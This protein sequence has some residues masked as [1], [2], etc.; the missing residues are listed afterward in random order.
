MKFPSPE[1][2]HFFR[3]ASICPE[4]KVADI[5]FNRDEIIKIIKDL[6]TKNVRLLLFPEL[7]I[8]GYTCGDLFYQNILQK[9]S[10]EAV[11]EIAAFVQ[12]EIVI[13]GLPLPVNGKLYNTAA[14]LSRGK[15]RAFIPKTY[16]PNTGEFYEER[17]FSSA[18]DSIADTIII[19][20]E[21]IPFGTDVLFT[22]NNFEGLKFGIEICEDL[23]AIEPPGIEMAKEGANLILNLSASNEILGKYHYRK[24]LVKQQSARCLSAYLYSSAGPG[25]SST[26]LVFSGH[27]LAAENGMVLAESR[28]Y[29]FETDTIIVDIDCEKLNQ[30]RVKNNSFGLSKPVKKF[31]E[32]H[33]SLDDFKNKRTELHRKVIASP[34]VPVNKEERSEVCR[35]IF[36]IQSTGLAKRLKHTN[37]KEVVLGISGGLDSTLAL[38]VTIEAFKK[39]NL[40]LSGIHTITMPGFATT[41]RTRSNAEELS[42]KTGT[43]LKII[44][45]NPAVSQHF[46]DIGQDEN[47]HDITYENSQARERTQILMDYA[48]KVNGLVIG[49]GDMSEL[50]LGWCTYN[51]DHM[52]MYG[53][54]AGVPKTLVRYLVEWVADTHFSGEIQTILHDIC[55]TPV[56]PELVPSKSGEGIEQKTEELIGPYELHDFFLYNMLRMNFR[57]IKI[58]FLALNAF[59]NKY[60]KVKILNWMKVFYKRFFTQQFKRSALPDGPKVGTVALSPRGDLRMPSDAS[61]TIWMNEVEEIEI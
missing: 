27:L 18:I 1:D 40:D 53:V 46:K 13:V 42:I 7:C 6:K 11:L 28:R 24:E 3:A 14:V 21:S 41:N 33:L 58:Y 59:G 60:S 36:S 37:T 26:D 25:E 22:I 17:W 29:S 30:E 15:I 48:N 51:G 50:A 20:G 4:L 5:P 23:W 61:F 32:I 54:N 43:T 49:T 38:L 8:T 35:E 34:F 52:S 19:N 55:D 10:L 56:S 57:P 45:I 44:E 47:N 16:L 39:L 2:L 31:R 12:E 9:K